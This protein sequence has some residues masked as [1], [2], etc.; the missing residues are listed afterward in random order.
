METNFQDELCSRADF[1]LRISEKITSIDKDMAVIRNLKKLSAG[2]VFDRNMF[3][4]L[5]FEDLA[6]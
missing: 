3:V 6:V 2:S 1:S 4:N 5:N